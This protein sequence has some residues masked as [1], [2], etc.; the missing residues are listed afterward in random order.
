MLHVL[1]NFVSVPWELYQSKLERLR[2]LWTALLHVTR[3]VKDADVPEH[4]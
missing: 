1:Q 2:T 4:R 3:Q